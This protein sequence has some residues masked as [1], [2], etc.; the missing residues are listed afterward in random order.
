MKHF[1][2]L[3]ILAGAIWVLNGCSSD[4]TA[5]SAGG[6]RVPGEVKSDEESRLQPGSGMTPNASLKW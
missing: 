6:E 2:M 3:A 5:A 4:E 1:L